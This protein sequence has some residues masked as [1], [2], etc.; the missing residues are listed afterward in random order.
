MTLRSPALCAILLSFAAPLFAEEPTITIK[1]QGFSFPAEL[2]N[3]KIAFIASKTGRKEVYLCNGDGSNLIQ[4]T[5]D[6]SISVGPA[7]SPDGRKL[8]YTG[9]QSGYA[10]IYVIDIGSGSRDRVVKFPGTNT[11]AAFSPDGSRLAFTASKDGNPELYVSSVGGGGATRLTRTPGVESSPTWSPRG[12]EIIYVSDQGGSPQLY[13]ISSGGGSGSRISTGHSY[14]TEPSWSPD[15][16]KVAFVTRSGGFQIAVLDLAS[17][18]CRVVAAGEDPSWAGDSRHL[19]FAS[20]SSLV[21]IDTA[22]GAQRTLASGL[23]KLSE[24]AMSR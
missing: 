7:L 12:D 1:K 8:A 9:Y 20:G 11:G 16:S 19:V 3:A 21:M 4:L 2:A 18:N 15:G 6:N 17:G 13:R 23:G 22:T 5:H 10:D 14:C 24:T